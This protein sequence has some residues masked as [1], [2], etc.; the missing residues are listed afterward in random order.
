MI[1]SWEMVKLT[2]VGRVKDGLPLAQGPRYLGTVHHDQENDNFSYYKQQAELLLRAISISGDD[3]QYQLAPS[4][5]TVL[6]D[7][8]CFKYPLIF[9]FGSWSLLNF[10]SVNTYC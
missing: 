1:I 5:M 6:F 9:Y 8:H 7:H 4:K 2:I 3:H 10:I